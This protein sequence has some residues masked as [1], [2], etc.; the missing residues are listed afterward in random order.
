MQHPKRN[1]L[2]ATIVLLALL[3]CSASASAQPARQHPYLYFTARDLPAL[4]ARLQQ[5]PFATRWQRLLE[6]AESC[7]H[8]SPPSPDRVM[9]NSRNSLGVAGTCAFA[10]ALTGDARHGARAKA[11][12]AALLQAPTWHTGYSWNHGA[13]LSTA[14]LCAAFALV[15]DWCYDTFTPAERDTVR[16]AALRLGVTPYLQSVEQYHDWWAANPVTNWRG[17]CNGGCGLA[18]LALYD[19]SPDARRAA[20]LAWDG[21]QD[22][23]RKDVLADG[24]GHEGVM[25]WTYGVEFSNYFLTAAAHVRGDDGGIF[26]TY[27]QKLAGY[28]PIYMQGPDGR[29]A[30]FNDMNEDTSAGLY[31]RNPRDNE[32][33]PNA[34]LCAL[35]ESHVPGGDPLLL[36]AADNGGANF[37]WEG[38]SPFWFIWRRDCPPAGPEPTLQDAVLFRGAGHAIL[39]SPAL[40]FDFNGGWTS[41][42]SHSNN[43]LGTFVLVAGGERFVNDPGYGIT[44]TGD[45]SSILVNGAGQPP[46]RERQVPALRQGQELLL[47]RLRPLDVLP[48]HEPEP[49]GA[50]RG[51]GGRRLHGAPRR[52][53]RPFAR[54]IRMAAGVT[55]AIPAGPGRWGGDARRQQDGPARP[56][57]RAA[58]RHGAGG[59]APVAGRQAAPHRDTDGQRPTPGTHA[60]DGHPHRALPDGRRSAGARRQRRGGRRPEGDGRG[61]A[62]YHCIRADRG[63]LDARQR[64]RRVGLRHPR[65]PAAEH[66]PVPPGRC[67]QWREV[68]TIRDL[69]CLAV[70]G[71]LVTAAGGCLAAAAVG[72]AAAGAG[73]ATYYVGSYEQTLHAPLEQVYAAAGATL[74]AQGLDIESE[75]RD[76]VTGHLEAEYADGKHVWL[77]M[78]AQADGTTLFSVRVGLVPDKDREATILA[79]VKKRL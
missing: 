65:R 36:W 75:K 31:S 38:A 20:D 58:G 10:Y 13:D 56:R 27:T 25:Y 60:A 29:F 52:T 46:E 1:P 12:L 79:D 69:T 48:A 32:G 26:E 5:E 21:L 49:L 40:W 77:N 70:C 59:H 15:W 16:S 19:E 44:E 66:R 57:R 42:A 39:S 3:L 74:R 4:K 51:D 78:E 61:P 18:A 43:D 7:L 76:K 63:R 64:Q 14:E 67:R 11:E 33:G 55:A 22:F 23:M 73:A 9:G 24:G 28:W 34:P 8:R 17:V 35:F 47:P 72:G 6:H 41:G 45:H 37:Y 50:A 2:R 54:A 71:L 68:M 53:D 62:G 30:N